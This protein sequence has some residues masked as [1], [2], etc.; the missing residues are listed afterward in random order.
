[1]RVLTQRHANNGLL[2]QTVITLP[3]MILN[4]QFGAA[5]AKL[6][7]SCMCAIPEGKWDGI[8]QQQ[9]FLLQANTALSNKL[10]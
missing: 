1:M 2:Y 10:S 4:F 6:E 8:L 5:A 7:P 3:N 9:S